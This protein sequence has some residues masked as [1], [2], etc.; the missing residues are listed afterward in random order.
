M[1]VWLAKD[2]EEHIY[3]F[4]S[5]PEKREGYWCGTNGGWEIDFDE[6]TD[7]EIYEQCKDLRPMECE[8]VDL[9]FGRG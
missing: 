7:P 5:Q 6:I 3:L 4:K 9:I 2:E 1:K 8:E